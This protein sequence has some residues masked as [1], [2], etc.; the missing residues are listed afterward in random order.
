MVALRRST[1]HVDMTALPGRNCALM[2]N[3]TREVSPTC[4]C[5]DVVMCGTAVWNHA[6]MDRAPSSRHRIHV[7]GGGPTN[8]VSADYLKPFNSC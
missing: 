1:K 4:R 3:V 7:M 5:A 2:P 6:A 8:Q